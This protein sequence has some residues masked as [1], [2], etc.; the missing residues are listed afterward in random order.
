MLSNSKSRP[1]P[2]S[3]I[4][5]EL[6]WI[7]YSLSKVEIVVL[8]KW[9]YRSP[10]LCWLL[11]LEWLTYL[12]REVQ[13]YFKKISSV[14]TLGATPNHIPV[15]YRCITLVVRFFWFVNHGHKPQ[16]HHTQWAS[17]NFVLTYIHWNFTC[18][19]NYHNDKIGYT[20]YDIYCHLRI[21]ITQSYIY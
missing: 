2:L 8:I 3:S 13:N 10:K 18:S 11:S 4:F 14:S 19:N 16:R 1:L 7:F 15:K 21:G 6:I 5:S 17:L 9:S 12:N 20:K